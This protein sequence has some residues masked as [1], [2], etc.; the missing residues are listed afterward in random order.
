M[1]EEKAEEQKK[2]MIETI[3]TVAGTKVLGPA[4]DKKKAAERILR[5]YEDR[6]SSRNE[7]IMADFEDSVNHDAKSLGERIEGH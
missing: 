5:S 6:S 3:Q 2:S 1:A 7:K 4:G